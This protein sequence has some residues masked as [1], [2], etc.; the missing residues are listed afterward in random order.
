MTDERRTGRP[1]RIAIVGV[2]LLGGSLA[3]ALRRAWPDVTIT[4]VDRGRRPPRRVAPLDAYAT[5]LGLVADA[6]VVVLAAPVDANLALLPAVARLVGADATITD[7]GS[8]KRA[9]VARARELSVHRQFVGGHPMAGLAVSGARHA[10]AGLFEHAPWALTPG[11]AGRVHVHR[12]RRLAEAV[13]AKPFAMSAAEHDRIVAFVSHLPQVIVSC[14]M[15][16]VGEVVGHPG[17]VMSGGGLY[18]TTRLATSDGRLWAAILEQNQDE[19]RRALAA[20]GRELRAV[21]RAL[22]APGSVE[23]LFEDA[24]RWRQRLERSRGRRHSTGSGG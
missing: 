13:G 22:Q 24:R 20:F 2:G 11:R 3:A 17:L 9:I 23:R 6:D 19:V 12:V 15:K 8:T 7:V 14:L 18:D 5:D 21:E 10:T 1:N 4:G 16:S